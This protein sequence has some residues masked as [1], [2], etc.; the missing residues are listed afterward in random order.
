MA[1]SVNSLLR[2]VQSNYPTL[3]VNAAWFNTEFGKLKK[4][5][6][7]IISVMQAGCLGVTAG[8]PTTANLPEGTAGLFDTGTAVYLAY[9][10][11]GTIK[12]VALT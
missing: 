10:Q 7:S 11:S 3:P 5:I 4:S 12:K 6:T 9:N 1:L 8:T 2:Y